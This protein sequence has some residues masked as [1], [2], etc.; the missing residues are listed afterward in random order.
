MA[1]G[2]FT[3]VADA[4]LRMVNPRAAALRVHHRRM[5]TDEAYAIA[6]GIECRRR[7]Y[8]AAKGGKNKTPWLNESSSSADAEIA[9]DHSKLRDRH[10]A[11]ERDESIASGIFLDFRRAVIGTGL[12]PQART[13]GENATTKNEAIEAVLVEGLKRSAAQYGL[14]DGQV[15]ELEYQG[16]LDAG[17][18]LLRPATT[19]PDQPVWIEDI[20]SDRLATPPD[21]MPRDPAGRIVNGVEKDALGRPVAYWVAKRH[22]GDAMP[23]NTV[24]GAAAKLVP[25]L[26][27]ADFDRVEIGDPE[28]PRC[29]LVKSRVTRAG[30]ARG[31]GLLHACLEDLHDL[32]LLVKASLKRA[33]VAACLAAFITSENSDIDL[34]QMTAQDYGYQLEQKLTPGLMWRLFPGEDVKFS[35][36][37]IN[38]PDLDKF[39]F[40]FASQ[41]GAAIGRSPQA[42][43]KAWAGVTYSGARTIKI[44]DKQTDRRERASYAEQALKFKARV[45]LED[46]LMRGDPRLVAAGVTVAD[47]ELIA[48]IGDE[49]QWVDPQAEAASIESMLEMSLTSPQIEC[50]RLGRDWQ[51]VIRQKLEAEKFEL[52]LRKK[53]KLPKAE[54]KPLK[55]LPGGKK[56]DED[57]AADESVDG[58]ASD[59]E[60]A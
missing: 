14:T 45:I 48:W 42:I 57:E 20:E 29:V 35:S 11:L 58:D 31:V 49:E 18:I 26:T 5:A 60:A 56:P 15:Q 7:G 33:Q 52:E 30:Q 22:P 27:A 36:P 13:K 12:R 43:L 37:S 24:L 16:T 25:S 41:I 50:A 9:G 59:K 46:A 32:D 39:V 1:D 3:R 53:M 17:D 44:D 10:R 38:A 54:P 28:R 8:A 51:D 6:F 4:F 40:M 34:I 21:A 23:A 2:L 55:V 19:G 47:F